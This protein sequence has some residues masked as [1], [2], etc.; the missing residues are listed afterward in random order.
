MIA[1]AVANGG[2]IM[3]PY[4]VDKETAPNGHVT[5]KGKD[6]RHVLSQAMSPATATPLDDM[7]QNVVTNG[8][9]RAGPGHP[10]RA[11]GRQD[12]HRAAR[13]RART[14]WPWFICYGTMNGKKRRGG[15]ACSRPTTPTIRDDISGSGFAGPIAKTVMEAALGVG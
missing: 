15:G 2:A 10:R 13:H 12:R 9:A 8:T 4:L 3:Q 7:M 11:H 1:A 5:Y 14:R 6:H